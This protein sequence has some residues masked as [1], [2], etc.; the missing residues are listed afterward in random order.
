[1]AAYTAALVVLAITLVVLVRLSLPRAGPALDRGVPVVPTG[2]APSARPLAEGCTHVYLDVGTNRGVQLRKLLQPQYYPGAKVLPVFDVFFGTDRASHSSLCAFGFEPNPSHTAWLQRIERAYTAHGWRVKV[3]TETAVGVRDGDTVPIYFTGDL[4]S[5]LAASST[6]NEIL[7][8]GGSRAP[9][10]VDV[11]TLDL[12]RFLN[13]EVHARS[14]AAAPG[15]A[16]VMKLDIE[17][18][19][20]DVL[21]ELL[22]RGALCKVDM[23]FAEFHQRQFN[24][25]KRKHEYAALEH[26]VHKHWWGDRNY[27]KRPPGVPSANNTQCRLRV[28]VLDDETYRYDDGRSFLKGSQTV[29]QG[30]K[31]RTPPLPGDDV[32]E[33]WK[34]IG[35]QQPAAAP[36]DGARGS[37]E[38]GSARQDDVQRRRRRRQ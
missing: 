11:R 27:T 35:T 3:F 14:E 6:Q 12:A 7:T 16:V 18:A 29:R 2:R 20:M 33:A 21:P 34:M 25:D 26:L 28:S 23:L 13:E 17:G 36:V 30:F 1:M 37:G 8:W 31:Q 15:A 32:P 9:K 19:E 22:L 38:A 4:F 10:R 24:E 5:D